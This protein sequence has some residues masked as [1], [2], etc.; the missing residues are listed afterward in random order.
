MNIFIF[1][2]GVS[3]A[4]VTASVVVV[5]VVAPVVVAPATALV[6]VVV[7]DASP[8]LLDIS[9]IFAIDTTRVAHTRGV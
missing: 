8:P 6:D 9:S 5:V 1:S 3:G 4:L 2:A 7:P